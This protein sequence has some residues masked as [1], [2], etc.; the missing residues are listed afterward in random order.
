[1][2]AGRLRGFARGPPV[3][4]IF[5]APSDSTP[6]L[7]GRV[8]F[9]VEVVVRVEDDDEPG[10]RDNRDAAV[11]VAVGVVGDKTSTVEDSDDSDILEA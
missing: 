4:A 6:P 2:E 9:G 1:V 8:G 7:T 3:H 11:V 10:G 5:S